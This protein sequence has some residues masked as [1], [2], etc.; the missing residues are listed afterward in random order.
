MYI[1]I[2]KNIQ[3]GNTDNNKQSTCGRAG[4]SFQPLGLHLFINESPKMASLDNFTASFPM[5]H[6]TLRLEYFCSTSDIG[7]RLALF[8][9]DEGSSPHLALLAEIT[10]GVGISSAE[11]LTGTRGGC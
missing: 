2:N 7:L 11:L 8:I 9:S 5:V 6:S 4:R 3:S 1:N 10:R